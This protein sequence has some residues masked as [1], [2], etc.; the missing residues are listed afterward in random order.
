MTEAQASDV[1]LDNDNVVSPSSQAR[2][3]P[4]NRWCSFCSIEFL[5]KNWARHLK[6][7]NHARHLIP[8]GRSPRRIRDREPSRDSVTG[9]ST[10]SLSSGR[11]VGGCPPPS[12]TPIGI[13]EMRRCAAVIFA[14]E[15]TTYHGFYTAA[16][17]CCPELPDQIVQRIAVAAE[18][19]VPVMRAF[20]REVCLPAVDDI[21]VNQD[22]PLSRSSHRRDSTSTR[23]NSPSII[24]Q[25]FRLVPTEVDV[26]VDMSLDDNIPAT[27]TVD[28]DLQ[29]ATQYP[30]NDLSIVLADLSL[31]ASFDLGR[32]AVPTGDEDDST[33]IHVVVLSPTKSDIRPEDLSSTKKGAPTFAKRSSP[34]IEEKEIDNIATIVDMS[35]LTVSVFFSYFACITYEL[36][37]DM[38]YCVIASTRFMR[39]NV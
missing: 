38:L 33:L 19:Y 22:V 39:T 18:I 16:K 7:G 34:S 24:E 32:V 3:R 1:E 28:A 10:R 27:A 13:D 4:R 36:S 14:V 20:A 31:D 30:S 29:A 11:P 12:L 17:R 8:D 26:N 21:D 2:Y 25:S 6:A 5:P 9:S 35:R 23:A 15:A 37:V